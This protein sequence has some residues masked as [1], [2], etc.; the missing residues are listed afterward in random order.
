MNSILPRVSQAISHCAVY[1][2]LKSTLKN[3]QHSGLWETLG[4]ML[5]NRL[6]C[7]VFFEV[8]LKKRKAR[9]INAASKVLVV[10][11]TRW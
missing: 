11:Q 10:S 1:N 7:C 8:D 3:T 4:M 9:N 5:S 2:L 6:L